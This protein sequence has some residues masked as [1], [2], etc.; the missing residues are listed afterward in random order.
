MSAV[1]GLTRRSLGS[2]GIEVTSICFGTSPLANLVELYGYAVEEQRAVETV[3]AIFAGPVNFL[4]TS[5]GYGEHGESEQRIGEA[6]RRS[7]GLPAGVVLATK[8]DPD[9]RTG[10]F[11]GARVRAS[12]EESL[13]RLGLDRVPLL[14]LHDPERMTFEAGVAAGGPLDALIALRDEGLVDYIGVAGG[15]VGLLGQYLAT[16]ALDYVLTHNRFTLMDRSAEA[17]LDDARARGMGTLNAAPYG[18]GM[19]VKGPDAQP[20]YAYGARDAGIAERA[21]AMKAACDRHGV[22]LAAA[23]LQFSVREPRIDS[24]VVGVSSPERIAQTV[25]LLDVVIPDELW[26]ELAGLT[27]PRELWLG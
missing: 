18:G 22:P 7:G 21:R 6:I 12:F 11:S 8:I 3:Q 17:L 10:D 19:L 27:A 15:P 24:T 14:S 26:D 13:A 1:R 25:A 9:P 16:E 20:R 5:N 2:T 23:A 4:D